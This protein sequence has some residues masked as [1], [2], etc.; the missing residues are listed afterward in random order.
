VRA[1][2]REA[3]PLICGAPSGTRVQAAGG[4]GL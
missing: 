1:L 3:M 4:K 2:I